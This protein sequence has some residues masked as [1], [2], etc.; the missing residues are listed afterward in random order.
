MSG[1]R[2]VTTVRAALAEVSPGRLR[3]M[4]AS[5]RWQSPA[6]GVVVRHS[7]PLSRAEVIEAEVLAHGPRAVL[8]DVHPLRWPRRTRT[9][10]SVVDAAAWAGSDLTAQA[11][12][13]AAVQ[14]GL[15]TPAS[16][17]SL[18]D[19]LPRLHRR[20]LI[21]ETIRDV[22]GGA[23]SEYEVLFTRMCRVHDLPRPDRQVRRR[24]ASGRMRYLDAVFDDYDLVVEID[25]Q[26]HMEVL[27]WWGDMMRD[28][29]LVAAG[30]KSL[31]RF[32]GFALRHEAVQV[33][34][35]LRR[36]FDTHQPRRC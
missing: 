24:D 5:G 12:L 30:G 4:V 28:N 29:E 6:R 14:Q 19:R 32:A 7:G 17:A 21:A 31:L 20:S 13:A 10:R 27:A 1:E 34:A 35:V 33:A 2:S 3:W 8:A 9:P 15:V 23:L 26:Q 18:L 36:F 11:I 22:A 25:G 16:L